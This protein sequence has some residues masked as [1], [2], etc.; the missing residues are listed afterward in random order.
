LISHPT[1]SRAEKREKALWGSEPE[2]ERRQG[3]SA[4]K[5]RGWQKKRGEREKLTLQ[6][7]M[8]TETRRLLLDKWLLMVVE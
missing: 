7:E 2:W 1:P 3:R 6:R 8:A 5:T 4:L